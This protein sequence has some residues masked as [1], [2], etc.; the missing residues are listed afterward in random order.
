ML[1]TI[2]GYTSSSYS[3][4]DAISQEVAGYLFVG[5]LV[6]CV[7][8]LIMYIVNAIFLGKV[9]QKAG[10]P[11]YIAWIPA[12]NIWRIFELGGQKG[13]LSLLTYASVFISSI[14]Q[15]IDAGLGV[16]LSLSFISGVAS[17]AGLVFYIMAMMN[18]GKNF[19]KSS[20]FV[21]LGIF[22]NVIWLGIL[23]FGKST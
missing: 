11:E 10:V 5:L 18:I 19:G 4:S 3:S 9:F 2:F 8:M 20:E 22:F 15:Q 13:Y 12:W 16:S 1:T 6:F 23:A 17:I 21:L 7:F 14:S